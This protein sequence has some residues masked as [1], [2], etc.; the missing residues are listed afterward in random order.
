MTKTALTGP[1]TAGSAG[2]TSAPALDAEGI[3]VS[4]GSACSSGSP[5]PSA[6]L[7]AAGVNEELARASLRISLPP[8]TTNETCREAA[9]R[10]VSTIGRVYEVANR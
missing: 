4:A 6:V 1:E 2:P 7:L 3:A 9:R 8:E 5:E 10:M